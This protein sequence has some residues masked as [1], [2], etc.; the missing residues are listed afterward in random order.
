[1]SELVRYHRAELIYRQDLQQWEPESHHAPAAETQESAPLRHPGVYVGNQV[2]VLRRLLPGCLPDRI[3][4][5]E[6]FRVLR[7]VKLGSGSLEAIAPWFHGPEYDPRS[8]NA[9]KREPEIKAVKIHDLC[10]RDVEKPPGYRQCET[11]KSEHQSDCKQSP[12]RERAGSEH[13]QT[14]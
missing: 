14:L 6:Q 2:H 8:G 10:I 12:E 5:L 4:N 7:C 3:E 13:M 11:V 9:E 1:M